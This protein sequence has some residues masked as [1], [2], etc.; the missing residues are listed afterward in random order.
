MAEQWLFTE[1][2]GSVNLHASGVS[3]GFHELG[4]RGKVIVTATSLWKPRKLLSS[5]GEFL[6]LEIP[7]KLKRDCG[8]QGRVV[9]AI[10]SYLSSTGGL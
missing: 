5:L 4:E 3:S 1:T 7:A 10:T 8:L 6:L 2:L 9:T